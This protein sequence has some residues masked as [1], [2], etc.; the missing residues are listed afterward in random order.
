MKKIFGITMSILLAISLSNCTKDVGPVE[1][2]NP[3]ADNVSFTQDIQPIFDQNCISCHPNSGNLDLTAA[4]AYN[5]LVN[6]NASGYSG[7]RVVP[8]APENSVLYKK[9][10]GSGTYGSNMPLGGSLSATQINNI[11][12]WI[13]EGAQNN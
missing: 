8:D 5:Q 6:I 1:E 12:Q 7:K 2:P 4:H 3:S 9:I 10:D 11:K 13:I